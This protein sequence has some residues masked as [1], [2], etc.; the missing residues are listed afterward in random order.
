MKKLTKYFV[1]VNDECTDD[2]LREYGGFSD[3]FN[4]PEEAWSDFDSVKD[5]YDTYQL[6]NITVEPASFKFK[7]KK[8]KK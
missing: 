5:D 4:T 1:R 8:K 3:G 2:T 6:V 7:R